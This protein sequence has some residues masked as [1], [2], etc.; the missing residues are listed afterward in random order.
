M[1]LYVQLYRENVAKGN[2]K[3]M[4]VKGSL[5]TTNWILLGKNK[6]PNS[7]ISYFYSFC[8]MKETRAVR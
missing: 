5:E 6:L 7:S 1:Q 8:H 2:V 4:Q 3:A